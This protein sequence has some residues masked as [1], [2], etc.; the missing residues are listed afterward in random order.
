[1]VFQYKY[2]GVIN[3]DALV[4]SEITSIS[5]NFTVENRDLNDL[6]FNEDIGYHIIFFGSLGRCF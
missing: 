6:T 5:L 1:M 2:V 3:I 4:R